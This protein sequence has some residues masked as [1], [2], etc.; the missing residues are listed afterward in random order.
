MQGD[1]AD[2]KNVGIA[3]LAEFVDHDAVVDVQAGFAGK[4]V[5]RGTTDA[6][7]HEIGRDPRGVVHVKPRHA[8]GQ[9]LGGDHLPAA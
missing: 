4:L 2:C 7:E 8:A 5:V 6:D 1:I 3:G 9:Q